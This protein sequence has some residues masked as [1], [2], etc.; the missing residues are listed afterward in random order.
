MGQE[1]IIMNEH[2]ENAI[3]EG[4]IKIYYTIKI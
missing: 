2:V 3:Y 1:I 4:T